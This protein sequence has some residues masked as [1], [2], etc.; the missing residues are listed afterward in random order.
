MRGVSFPASADIASGLGFNGLL[1]QFG[2]KGKINSFYDWQFRV[3]PPI[4]ALSVDHP[5]ND[6]TVLL[7][8]R[9][10]DQI[11]H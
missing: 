7:G 3:E 10:A 5:R 8:F 11:R 6:E 2:I 9:C 4:F 1:L